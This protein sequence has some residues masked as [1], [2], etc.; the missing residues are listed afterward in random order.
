MLINYTYKLS[1]ELYMQ[2]GEMVKKWRKVSNTRRRRSNVSDI[3]NYNA[4]IQ[5]KRIQR[6]RIPRK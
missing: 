6:K 4:K 3:V 5:R 1:L 2:G